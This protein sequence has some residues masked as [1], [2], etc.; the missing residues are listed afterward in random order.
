[1]FLNINK[2]KWISFGKKERNII[3]LF[4]YNLS[5]HVLFRSTQKS[6]GVILNTILLFNLHIIFIIRKKLSLYL[7]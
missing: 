6:I 7:A 5:D 3:I 2:L 1:M 4:N